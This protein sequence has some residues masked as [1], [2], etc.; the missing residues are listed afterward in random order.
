M[1]VLAKTPAAAQKYTPTLRAASATYGML[2]RSTRW[3]RR[4][5]RRKAKTY[6]HGVQYAT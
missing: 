3:Y 4:G 5:S 2:R 1:A 6:R